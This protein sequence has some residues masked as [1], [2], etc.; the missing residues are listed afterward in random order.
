MAI[1]RVQGPDGRI[2]RFEGPDNATPQEVEAFAAQTFGD[3][4]RKANG[5]KTADGAAPSVASRVGQQ[6]TNAVAGAVRG[7][8]SIGATILTP[9]DA[10][11][12]ALGIQNEFIGRADRRQAM[13]EALGGLG[14]DTDSLAYGGGKLAAEIAGTSGVGGLLAK[15]A[16]A[17]PG[18]AAKV[19]SIIEAIRTAGMS[20]GQ[21]G[22]AARIAGGAITGGA[23]AGLVNPEDAG[24]GAAVGGAAPAVVRTLGAAGRAVGRAVSPNINNP[25]LAR[26][27]VEQYGIPLGSADISASRGTK[28]LRSVLNDAPFVGGIG[29]RQGQRVQEG[30]NRAVGRTFGADAPSLTPEVVDAAKKRMGAE[31]DRIWGQNR[32]TVDVD[33]AMGLK[34]LQDEVAKLP[35]GDAARLDSWLR[36]VAGKVVDDGS[37]NFVIPGEVANRLQSKLRVDADKAQGFLKDSMQQLRR[38][39]LD[40]F[41]RGV[42]PEDAA[43][44]ANNR[45]QYKAFKTVEP[46]LQSAEA[47][48]AGRTM[49]DIPAGLLPQAVRQSYRGGIAQ[50][51]FADLTQI[52]SQYLADRVARTGGGPRAMI[53]NSALGG[54]VTLGAFA[55]PMT[56]AAIPTSAALQ[57]ALGSPRVA[58]AL[59][60]ANATGAPRAAQAAQQVLAS[61]ALAGLFYRAAPVALATSGDP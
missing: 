30:F 37:G 52:G 55:E 28:A 34:A 14:A 27:A 23:S 59:L 61:P 4:Q 53:Q 49:G 39:L 16:A 36:D 41:N 17:V 31:F 29:E 9:V 6:L 12:R 33:M 11:A 44:L 57:Q 58:Q 32:L 2:H 40:A 56:L 20:A 47:G 13:D 54:A 26:K 35:Q 43:A 45:A 60:R 7:A 19:P 24:T 25:E 5:P 1:Y 10:A 22:M 3:M 18:A 38:T 21:G 50:S 42:S 8:G 48:V 15:G 46:L 51:P